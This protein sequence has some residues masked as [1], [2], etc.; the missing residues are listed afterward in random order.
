MHNGR[1]DIRQMGRV[2][3]EDGRF[4]DRTFRNVRKNED[5]ACRSAMEMTMR[6]I[7]TDLGGGRSV[8][9]HY[10]L[11]YMRMLEQLDRK[12]MEEDILQMMALRWTQGRMA[13]AKF[14]RFGISQKDPH[15]DID[16]LEWIAR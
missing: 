1:G 4:G 2:K 12:D 9:W 7:T 16:K 10:L 8:S 13:D 5:F 14:T 6:Q 11:Y 15:G 3:F